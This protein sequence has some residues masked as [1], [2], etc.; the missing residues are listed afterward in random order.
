MPAWIQTLLNQKG[1]A[2]QRTMSPQEQARA[3]FL[4]LEPGMLD[5]GVLL[6]MLA[7]ELATASGFSGALRS[8]QDF[9]TL[10]DAQAR[11]ACDIIPT[12]N[13]GPFGSTIGNAA[14]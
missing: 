3:A 4:G 2:K 5:P 8:L 1:P 12:L 7:E 14:E 11:L 6:G 13:I 10:T 9:D